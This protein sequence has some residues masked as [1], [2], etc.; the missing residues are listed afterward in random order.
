[1]TRPALAAQHQPAKSAI[2]EDASSGGGIRA[3][4]AA[5]ASLRTRAYRGDHYLL[6]TTNR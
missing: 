3:A 2:G 4:A 1:M 5:S 6:A